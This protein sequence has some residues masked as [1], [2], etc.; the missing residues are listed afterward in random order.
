MRW[1]PIAARDIGG[2]AAEDLDASDFEQLARRHLQAADVRRLKAGVESAA[3]RAPDRFG[4]LGDFLAH[5]VIEAGLVEGFVRPG[6]RRRRLRGGAAVERR[7]FEAIG[8][9]DGDFAVVEMHDALGVTDQRGRIGGD[10]HFPIADAEDDRAAVAS[11]DDRLR[12]ALR[13]VPRGHRFR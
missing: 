5:V 6:D 4:L 3:Q 1:A 2:A 10:E 11:D 9:H 8:A 13:R 12:V 7:C